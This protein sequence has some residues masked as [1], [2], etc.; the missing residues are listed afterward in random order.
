MFKGNEIFVKMDYSLGHKI[1]QNIK[2]LKL[3]REWSDQNGFKLQIARK[4]LKHLEINHILNSLFVLIFSVIASQPTSGFVTLQ[5][6]FLLSQL[7][8]SLCQQGALREV[9]K[10]EREEFLLTCLLLGWVGIINPAR[11]LCPVAAADLFSLRILFYI[12]CLLNH[13]YFSTKFI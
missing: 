11:L 13:H 10:Q 6:V 2:R 12:K 4:C 8:V 9:W 7:A 1:S 5:S 3:S